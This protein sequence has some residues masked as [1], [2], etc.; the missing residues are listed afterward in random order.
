MGAPAFARL[1]VAVGAVLLIGVA[2][3]SVAQPPTVEAR[4]TSA[5][6]KIQEVIAGHLQELNGKFKLRVIE[7]TF[8]PD[9]FLGGHHHFG[10]GRRYV[11]A[12]QL[13]FTQG[14]KATIHK[15]GDYFFASGNIV[16]SSIV[17]KS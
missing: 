9:G 16:P 5:K 2:D 11:A 14:G 10:P 1:A 17:P 3:R 6:M 8:E 7:L 12:G 15:A 4:G 13:V